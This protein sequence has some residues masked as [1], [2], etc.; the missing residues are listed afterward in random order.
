MRI[1]SEEQHLCVYKRLFESLS[2]KFGKQDH[3]FCRTMIFKK[4]MGGP[5]KHVFHCEH[6]LM[7]ST[8]PSRKEEKGVGQGARKERFGKRVSQETPKD[9]EAS[10]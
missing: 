3:I 7:I 10:E 8:H 9:F 4:N 6:L 5:K 1:K 2:L